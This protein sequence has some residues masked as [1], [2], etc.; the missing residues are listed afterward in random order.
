MDYEKEYKLLKQ[1]LK[2]SDHIRHQWQNALREL[3]RTKSELKRAQEG[4]EAKVTER[5]AEL[6]SSNKVLKA[7]VERRKRIELSMRKLTL[8]VEQTGSVVVITDKEGVIQ[9]VNPR[10]TEVTGYTADEAIGENPKILKSGQT[11]L[12]IYRDMWE[13]LLAGLHWRGELLNKNKNGNTYWSYLSISPIEDD[14]GRITHFVGV[15]EDV[16]EIKAAHV[17]MTH[18]A[19]FDPLTELPN[20]RQ[21]KEQLSQALKVSRRSDQLLGLMFLD[22]DN[23][24][25][26]NDTLGHEFGDLLLKTVA[27]RL[28][29]LLRET[30]MVARFGGDEFVILLKEISD[31]TGAKSVAEKILASIREPIAIQ[32]RRL[33]TS[34][35]IG[36]TIAPQ[37]GYDSETLMRN[38][39]LAMYRAKDK[40][41]NNY[42]YFTEAMN[43]QV[44]ERAT[45][46]HELTQALE[47]GQL[48][49]HLQPVLAM[50]G[51]RTVGAE[52]LL[53]WQHP[54]KG[55]LMPASFIPIAEESNLIIQVGEWVMREA[56]RIVA[57]LHRRGHKDIS[58]A[59]NISPKQFADPGFPHW[60]HKILKETG[61]PGSSLNLEI[62]ETT[63][64][65]D[66]DHLVESLERLKRLDV[67]ISVDDFGTGYSSLSY[68]KRLPVD[69]VKIDQS[70]IRDIHEDPADTGIIEAIIAMARKLLLQ[71]IAEGVETRQQLDFLV[72]NACDMAQGYLLGRPEP[73]NAL[74]ERLRQ[75]PDKKATVR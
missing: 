45:V 41:R 15:S 34:T 39:D 73:E 22:L 14:T 71:V 35:S 6:K 37:D 16:T 27:E 62:T 7:E 59:V 55:L 74:L 61:T 54:E 2:Q 67:T 50:D 47:N 69:I 12:E 60:V 36:I 58:L 75:G 23:F 57:D 51:F 53:R 31:P 49:L 42:Q 28:R 64:M 5:T 25:S 17:R 8:A 20:R 13:T 48:R 10:F 9:Y 44:A 33:H 68:L 43:R 19:L 32:G 63:L 21:L 46:E 18:M 65:H 29:R 30:D 11:P 3:Q 70:F 72:D 4:L 26:I 52:A 38:A 66:I 24:K 1:A 56:C 40:G